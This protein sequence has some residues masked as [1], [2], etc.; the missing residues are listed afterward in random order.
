MI[1]EIL[2][3]FNCDVDGARQLGWR[4]EAVISL[5]TGMNDWKRDH[6]LDNLEGAT[7]TSQRACLRAIRRAK[8]E[9]NYTHRDPQMGFR[10]ITNVIHHP[11][12][13]ED[14]NFTNFTQTTNYACFF[15]APLIS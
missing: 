2:S 1:W 8:P 9:I 3:C 13:V 4:A 6:D 12:Y 15:R 7:F 5:G 14:F 10:I 11:D